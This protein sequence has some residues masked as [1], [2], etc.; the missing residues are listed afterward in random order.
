MDDAASP[1]CNWT[2]QPILEHEAG[3]VENGWGKNNGLIFF[4]DQLSS[5]RPASAPVSP[6]VYIFLVQQD[7]SAQTRNPFSGL[8]VCFV[9]DDKATVSSGGNVDEKREG[10]ITAVMLA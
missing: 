8:S 4:N 1:A 9:C 5:A 2:E 7:D 10:K 6:F 3:F